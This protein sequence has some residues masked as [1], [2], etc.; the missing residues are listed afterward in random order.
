MPVSQT[1]HLKTLNQASG[2]EGVSTEM[3]DLTADRDSG[4]RN[5]FFFLFILFLFPCPL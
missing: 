4:S 1:D 5:K 3:P 2:P